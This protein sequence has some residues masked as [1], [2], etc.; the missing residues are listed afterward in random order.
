MGTTVAVRTPQTG[1]CQVEEDRNN[2]SNN[3]KTIFTQLKIGQI[4][5]SKL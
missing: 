5:E 1:V 3:C 2:Y 4:M